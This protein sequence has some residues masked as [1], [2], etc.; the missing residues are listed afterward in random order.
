MAAIP[1]LALDLLKGSMY[2]NMRGLLRFS[3]AV[4]NGI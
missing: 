3:T 2:L 4:K 1:S